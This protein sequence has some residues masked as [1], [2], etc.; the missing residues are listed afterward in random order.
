MKKLN[1]AALKI[2]DIVLTTTMDRLSKGVRGVIN[3][4]ISHALVYVESYSVVDSTSEGVHSRNTQRLF[5]DDQCAI[6][7]LR[8]RE[9]LTEHQEHKIITYMRGRI[10]TRYSKI[11]AAHSVIGGRNRATRKQFCSRLVAQ[12][13]ASADLNLVASPD[14]CTPDDLKAS[15]RLIAVQ[16]ATQTV[17]AHRIDAMNKDF[18]TT[19]LMRDVI[20]AVLK[21]ARAKN[22]AIEDLNDIDLHLI[23][24]PID[25]AHFA[26]IFRDSGY[27]TVWSVECQKNPWQYALSL[28]TANS[29]PEAAKQQYC[30]ELV[31]DGERG[32]QRYG[33]N[34][35][36]YAILVEEFQLEEE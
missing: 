33:V 1:E 24:T 12:A 26:G 3:S 28:M 32:L 25:D 4:D 6:Y 22:K 7:V 2:G 11:E 15:T 8:L 10:G 29:I 35:A 30:E 21:E 14:Y 23:K 19:Q 31:N 9:G 27:L 5:L 17:T 20:N 34:R 16:G 18:D 13:Y 36:G